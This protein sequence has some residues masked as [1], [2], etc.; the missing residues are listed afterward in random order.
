M[1]GLLI[2]PAAHRFLQCQ[3]NRRG[4]KV[5]CCACVGFEYSEKFVEIEYADLMSVTRGVSSDIKDI[6]RHLTS[7]KRYLHKDEVRFVFGALARPLSDLKKEAGSPSVVDLISLD[8]E[9]AEMEVLKGVDFDSH[10]FRYML[11]E[12]RILEPLQ[13]FLE[14][15]GY[16]LEAQLTKHDYLFRSYSVEN[17]I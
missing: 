8:V 16:T 10:R 17:T 14:R 6:D 1:T 5:V 2:E 12:C 3:V 15:R 9:G 4:S 7:A 11:I 13:V